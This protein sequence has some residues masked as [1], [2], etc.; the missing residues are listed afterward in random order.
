MTDEAED[1]K[2]R[3]QATKAGYI[4]RWCRRNGIGPEQVEQ[5]TDGQWLAAAGAIKHEAAYRTCRMPSR[6]GRTRELVLSMLR[7]PPDASGEHSRL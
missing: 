6:G 3:H 4:A 7:E 5:W 1:V 2:L